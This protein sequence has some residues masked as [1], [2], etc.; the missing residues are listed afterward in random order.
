MELS[1]LVGEHEVSLNLFV[2]DNLICALQINV[3]DTED[4]LVMV[5]LKK[6]D[7]K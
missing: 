7:G 4:I 3:Q 2:N 1:H 5:D 6:V